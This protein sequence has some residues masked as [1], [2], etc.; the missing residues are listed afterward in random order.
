MPE[1]DRSEGHQDWG[2]EQYI[3]AKLAQGPP[4]G[5]WINKAPVC[6][7]CITG[8][9]ENS[10]RRGFINPI[11]AKDTEEQVFACSRCGKRLT[12]SA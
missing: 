2:V 5:V 10:L 1:D 11:S 3:D 9:E 12:A 4:A 8:T 7:E 6:R